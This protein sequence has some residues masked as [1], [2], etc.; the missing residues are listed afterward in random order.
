MQPF[1]GEIF[2]LAFTHGALKSLLFLGHGRLTLVPL[3][4][5]APWLAFIAAPPECLVRFNPFASLWQR[6]GNWVLWQLSL[7]IPQL[8]GYAKVTGDQLIPILICEALAVLFVSLTGG[9]E[10]AWA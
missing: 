6:M 1:N 8:G 10:A 4:L 9:M 7:S 5:P 3:S 2:A